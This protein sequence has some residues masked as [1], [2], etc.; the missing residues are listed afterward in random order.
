MKTIKNLSVILSLVLSVVGIYKALAG[1]DWLPSWATMSE[2]IPYDGIMTTLAGLALLAGLY[3]VWRVEKTL[4]RLE[5]RWSAVER[6]QT[7]AVEK[8]RNEQTT[9]LQLVRDAHEN[10]VRQ[11]VRMAYGQLQVKLE[12]DGRHAVNAVQRFVDEGFPR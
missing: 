8:F 12:S 11:E 7:E 10:E 1:I 3:R 2:T 5:T 4:V 9:A 6:E